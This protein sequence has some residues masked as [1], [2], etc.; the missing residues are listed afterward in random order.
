MSKF[1][2][3]ESDEGGLLTIMADVGVVVMIKQI[4]FILAY[5]LLSILYNGG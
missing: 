4:K 3:A 1:A 2:D 5:N